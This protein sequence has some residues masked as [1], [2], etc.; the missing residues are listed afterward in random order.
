[1]TNIPITSLPSVTTPGTADVFPVVQ[2]GTTKK[3]T[4]SLAFSIPP[5][6]GATTP[7]AGS[8]TAMVAGAASVN[9]VTLSGA[10]SGS[11]P[12]IVVSGLDTNIDLNL[13][14]KGTGALT[15][16]GAGAVNAKSV[17]SSAAM[18]ITASG[19]IAITATDLVVPNSATIDAGGTTEVIIGNGTNALQSSQFS[20]DTSGNVNGQNL[21][22]TA[23]FTSGPGTID[24]GGGT[25][26]IIGNG[27]SA[28]QS[29]L[30]LVDSFGNVVGSAFHLGIS[31]PDWS[32]GTGV[33]VS[34]KPRGSLYSRGDGAVGSTLYVS[35]GGG[36]WNAVAGV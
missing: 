32:N 28:L 23:L 34:T 3:L 35:Q 9:K 10:G 13:T 26:V 1:M 4:L 19:T 12:A 31:G 36:T 25:Q 22:G 29:N 24:Q 8:F 30:F 6:I 5:A 33:P 11:G 21:S 27:T 20:V 7:N 15:V 14:P 18:Q 2:A 16:N 17:T